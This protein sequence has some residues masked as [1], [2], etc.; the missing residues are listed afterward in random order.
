MTRDGAEATTQQSMESPTTSLGAIAGSLL[1]D[2]RASAAARLEIAR[3]EGREAFS[4]ALHSLYAGCAALLLVLVAWCAACAALVVFAVE[5]GASWAAALIGAAV[6]N[7]ALAV[8]AG[9]HARSRAASVG[10]PHTRRLLLDPGV[11]TDR[12][13][14]EA[15]DAAA[16]QR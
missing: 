12:T 16:R 8:W 9:I 15:G 1:G 13:A 6:A 4:A 10:M 5:A 14:L 2:L 7:A 11:E 3:I